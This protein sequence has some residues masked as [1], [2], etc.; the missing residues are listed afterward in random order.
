MIES[1]I[2]RIP[3][4]KLIEIFKDFLEDRLKDI[5]N[6]GGVWRFTSVK[7]VFY[8][9]QFYDCSNSY[10]IIGSHLCYEDYKLIGYDI[11]N[12]YS[13]ISDP[14]YVNIKIRENNIEFIDHSKFKDFSKDEMKKLYEMIKNVIHKGGKSNE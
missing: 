8:F 5:E 2:S 14:E 7:D 9:D 4:D 6:N 12:T 11:W 13:V 10:S 3:K 1:I